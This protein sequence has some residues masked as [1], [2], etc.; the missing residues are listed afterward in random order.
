MNENQYNLFLRVIMAERRLN[1]DPLNRQ[2][3]KGRD[4]LLKDMVSIQCNTQTSSPSS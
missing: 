3:A 1:C 2:Q 4:S